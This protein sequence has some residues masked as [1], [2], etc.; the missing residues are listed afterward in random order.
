M[1]AVIY[2][3]FIIHSTYVYSSGG[4]FTGVDYPPAPRVYSARSLF[5]HILTDIFLMW[6]GAFIGVD[7]P[8]APWVYSA[9]YAHHLCPGLSMFM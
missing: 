9:L 2:T 1:S 8:P 3:F 7:Y 4:A 5:A 6:C